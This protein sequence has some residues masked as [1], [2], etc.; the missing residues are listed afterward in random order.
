[1]G[2]RPKQKMI[3]GTEPESIPEIEEAAEAY[4]EARDARMN[5]L[6]VEI[7][8]K[9]EL[10]ELMKKHKLVE[11][12]YDG[13]VVVMESGEPKV[14]VKTINDDRDETDEE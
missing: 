9:K 12:K 8:R 2:R 1:M 7:E 14:R 3:E 5:K 13:H 6:T 4:R 11:H 10:A